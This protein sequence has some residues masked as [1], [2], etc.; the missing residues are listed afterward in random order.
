[1]AV[2]IEA[3]CKKKP[4]TI[5]SETFPANP[6]IWAPGKRE[7]QTGEKATGWSRFKEIAIGKMKGW[8]D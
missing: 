2:E 3:G 5:L 1:M 4:Q 6:V 8:R 7:A